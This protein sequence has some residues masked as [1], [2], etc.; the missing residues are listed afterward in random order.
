MMR[1]STR[2]GPHEPDFFGKIDP[3]VPKTGTAQK[4]RRKL[5]RSLPVNQSI[6]IPLINIVGALMH[7]KKGG[8]KRVTAH[9]ADMCKAPHY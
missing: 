7:T 3:F 5:K 1:V 4:G 2:A 8:K 9:R 6:T